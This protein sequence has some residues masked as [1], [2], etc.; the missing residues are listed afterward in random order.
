MYS[1]ESSSWTLIPRLV[2]LRVTICARVDVCEP[3]GALE[4]WRLQG[5]WANGSVHPFGPTWTQMN[6]LFNCKWMCFHVSIPTITNRN[7]SVANRIFYWKEGI[8][9]LGAVCDSFDNC[10]PRLNSPSRW[11]VMSNN[12][13][14]V[15][16]H[17]RLTKPSCPGLDFCIDIFMYMLPILLLTTAGCTQELEVSESICQ[18]MIPP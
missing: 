9:K 1:G 17:V 3:S 7:H 10:C 18:Y 4:Q 15:H 8:S 5:D 11:I 13:T 12:N 14:V 6:V 2:S 16:E